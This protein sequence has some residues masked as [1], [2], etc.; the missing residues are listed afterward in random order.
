[1]LKYMI[2]LKSN[3]KFQHKYRVYHTRTLACIIFDVVQLFSDSQSYLQTQ[4]AIINGRGYRYTQCV[5]QLETMVTHIL[6]K[7]IRM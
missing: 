6:E 5:Y 7:E 4:I 1:M 3:L 2:S